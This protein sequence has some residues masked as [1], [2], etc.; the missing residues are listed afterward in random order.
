M[1]ALRATVHTTTRALP[2]QLVFGRDSIMNIQ[3]QADW[4]AI[5]EFKQT[6]IR[7]DNQRENAKRIPHEYQA[8]DQVLIKASETKWKFQKNPWEGPHTIVKVND[9]GTV[10]LKMGAVTDTIN[11]RLIKPY[12]T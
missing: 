9:N 8:G 11:I 4:N 3:F 7:K 1:F 10:R 2:A 5:K 6:R 12:K